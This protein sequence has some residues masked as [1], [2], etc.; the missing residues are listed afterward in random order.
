MWERV[1]FRISVWRLQP[2]VEDVERCLES[3][4]FRVLTYLHKLTH[5]M[6]S[7]RSFSDKCLGF[8][9]LPVEFRVVKGPTDPPHAEY[10][11]LVRIQDLI[12]AHIPKEL[13]NTLLAVMIAEKFTHARRLDPAHRECAP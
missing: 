12:N 11:H 4:E 1:L 5:R 13:Q 7:W 10:S 2:A 9:K 6:V 3:P 8:E